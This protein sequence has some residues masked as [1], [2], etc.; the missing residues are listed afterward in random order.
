M[1]KAHLYYQ[2]LLTKIGDT[3][4]WYYQ[5]FFVCAEVG[6]MMQAVATLTC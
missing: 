2:E 4:H 6:N 1:F 3:H 5:S